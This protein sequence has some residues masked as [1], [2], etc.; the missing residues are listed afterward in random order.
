MSYIYIRV[1]L[2]FNFQKKK[3]PNQHVVYKI[4][5]AQQRQCPLPVPFAGR[6][7]SCI[8]KGIRLKVRDCRLVKKLKGVPGKQSKLRKK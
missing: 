1:F 4:I 2:S 8:A 6:N 3:A 7:G 5:P